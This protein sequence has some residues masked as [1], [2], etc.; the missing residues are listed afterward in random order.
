MNSVQK[1]EGIKLGLKSANRQLFNPTVIKH[2]Q[3]DCHIATAK[4]CGTHWIK[5]MLSLILCEIYDLPPPS[6][7]IEDSIL[8]HP[9]TP[10]KYDHIPQIAVTHSHPHY[11]IHLPH[12]V[13]QLNLPKFLVMVRDPRDIL[14]SAYEKSKGTNFYQEAGLDKE[15]SFSDFIRLDMNVKK[16]R[17]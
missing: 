13:R 15:Y 17:G 7:V 16:T 10:P 8:G 6:H 3:F 12:A 5:Y 1:V 9:K 11:L 2:R 14:V 4:Q